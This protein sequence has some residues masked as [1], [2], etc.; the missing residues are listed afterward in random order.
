MRVARL[1]VLVLA[2][3]A[4]AAVPEA[5]AQRRELTV[6]VGGNYT[7]VTS[8]TL[9]KSESRTGFQGGIS[10]RIPRSPRFSF[11]SE[12][13]LVQ[14]RIYGERAQSS[15][16][17]LLVGPISDAANLLYAQ[18][19]LLLRFQ[20]GYSTERP[21]RPFLVLG[22]FVSIRMA[23]RRDVVEAD[24]ILQHTDCSSTP[25]DV[26]PGPRPFI[27]ALY[28][29]MDVGLLGALGV[30]IRRFSFSVRGERSFRKLVEPGAL[31]TSPL[32]NARFWTASASIEYLIRVL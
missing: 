7:G 14:R 24:S 20:H 23:C 18:I 5:L 10:L 2:G 8:S 4:G 13:L 28:Q 19:P 32:D 6:V 29:T 21:V 11:Q 22:P 30:E 31:P 9:F 25:D 3:G 17:P 1:T 26:V 16:N 15:Q 27:P 12:L